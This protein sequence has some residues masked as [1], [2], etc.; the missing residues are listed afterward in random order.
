M[1][2]SSVGEDMATEMRSRDADERTQ[3]RRGLHRRFAHCHPFLNPDDF[4]SCET[5]SNSSNSI[6]FDNFLNDSTHTTS[7]LPLDGNVSGSGDVVDDSSK[8]QR[9]RSKSSTPSSS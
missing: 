6:A 7:A 8:S 2:V 1:F 5:C 3:R 9:N 4:P